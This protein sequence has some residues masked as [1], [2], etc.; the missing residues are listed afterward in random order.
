[1]TLPREKIRIEL[2]RKSNGAVPFEQWF[3]S[4]RSHIAQQTVEARINRIRLGNFGNCRQ[5]GDGVF[6]LKIDFGP[7]YRVYFCNLSGNRI[8]ILC[9][10]D[11]SSQRRDIVHAKTFRS[12]F[13][14]SIQQP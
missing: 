5:V 8:L 11:K 13:F 7:G 10:G 9:A 3:R 6:E 12:I 2:F 1:M 14:R 4:R